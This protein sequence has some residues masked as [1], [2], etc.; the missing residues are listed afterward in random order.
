MVNVVKNPVHKVYIRYC[1]IVLSGSPI[2]RSAVVK[3]AEMTLETFLVASQDNL[4]EAS[5]V[6]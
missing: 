6:G 2:S 5:S 1:F 3:Q 4:C